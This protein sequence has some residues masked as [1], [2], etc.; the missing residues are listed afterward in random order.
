MKKIP[1]CFLTAFFLMITLFPTGIAL[2]NDQSDTLFIVTRTQSEADVL[3][4]FAHASQIP[5]EIILE[6]DYTSLPGQKILTT[7]PSVA[8]DAIRAGSVPLCVG[9]DFPSTDSVAFSEPRSLSIS[10]AFGTH[11]QAETFEEGIRFIEETKGE[12]EG[13][14]TLANGEQTPFAAKCDEGWYIPWYNTNGLSAIALAEIIGE[15]CGSGEGGELFVVIDEIYPFSDLTALKE[16]S[17]LLYGAG[18]PFIARVMPV[19]NNL[20]YPA[21]ARYADA[22]RYVQSRNGT[23]VIH[24]FIEVPDEMEREPAADRLT[25]FQ[26][27][28]SAQDVHYF[29]MTYSPFAVSIDELEK[30]FSGTKDFGTFGVDTMVPFTLTDDKAAREEL[31]R[32]INDKWLSIEDYRLRY[33]TE[34]YL[35]QAREISEDY[36]Y[37]KEEERT[38]AGLFAAGNEVFMVIVMICLVIFGVLMIIGFRLYRRKFFK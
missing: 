7:L 38:L 31:L 6:D 10:F 28:L 37:I 26:D 9:G 5:T 33:T 14:L 25:R 35:Y 23:I 15:Y 3:A 24:D 16:T 2:A 29:P 18:V 30:M 20:D 4:S 19:Y 22:L 13:T 27:A 32:R 36:E 1:L 11:T 12:T 34:R 21:F 17:D 8:S